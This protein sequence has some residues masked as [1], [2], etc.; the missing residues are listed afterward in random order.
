VKTL[1]QSED[2]RSKRYV[3]WVSAGGAMAPI[4]C[5]VENISRSG[6]TLRVFRSAVPE[7]FTLH[8]NRGGDAK[9]R[10]HVVQCALPQCDVEFIASL[11]GYN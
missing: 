3:A 8:F 4:R 11:E 1:E 10:C 6:A 7:E 9:I 5:Y 2:G